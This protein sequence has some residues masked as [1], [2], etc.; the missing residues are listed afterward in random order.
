[1]FVTFLWLIVLQFCVF[2]VC[3][4]N[5]DLFIITSDDH[6]EN[7]MK[8][9]ELLTKFCGI[10]VHP[11]LLFGQN[12]LD[13][14]RSGLEHSNFK[15]IFIDDG[16]RE[17]DLV[18]FGTDAALMQMIHSHD[19]SIIPVRAHSGIVIPSLLRMFRSLDVHKLLFGKR[20]DDVD[21]KMLAET[22]IDRAML[23]NIVKILSKS[24]CG[25]ALKQSAGDQSPR[26]TFQHSEILRKN[27]LFLVDHM[28][29]DH[30]LLSALCSGSVISP[31]EME[32]IK[33]QKTSYDRNEYLIDLLR[34]KS[35]KDFTEFIAAL[36]STEQAHIADVLNPGE[37]QPA[38]S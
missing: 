8:L 1:M 20:L 18:K 12:K 31:R 34:R 24:V 13:H 5:F 2:V 38:V 33:S 17:S 11:E 22:D 30:G 27:Y 25:A 9:A 19:Q 36:L 26:L 32:T 14:L 10:T 15:F 21:V 23:A 16:F 37:N 7:A 35:G 3:L 6:E 29:P 28:N 4:D